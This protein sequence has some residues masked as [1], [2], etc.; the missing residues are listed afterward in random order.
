MARQSAGLV[1]YRRRDRGV[2]IFLAHPGGPFWANKDEGAWS[3]PK[4]EF[5]DDEDPLVAAQRE[6]L[7]ETGIAIAGPFTPLEPIKQRGGKIVH[8][9]MVEADFDASTVVSNR[10][11]ME[12]PPR[13]GKQQEFPEVDRGEWFDFATALAKINEGQRGLLVQLQVLLSS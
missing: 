2:E 13:S 10:F 8:A 3:I 1:V 7:E 6:F 9:W 12:W 5:A 11:T 4:G